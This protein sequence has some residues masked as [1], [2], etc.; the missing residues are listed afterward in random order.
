MP[1]KTNKLLLL[2]V[3]II[4]L[5]MVIL[6][7]AAPY[8]RGTAYPKYSTY[9][10][11]PIGSKLFFN[12]L[13]SMPNL[14]VE[15]IL[16]PLFSA[17]FAPQTTIINCGVP[18]ADFQSYLPEEEIINDDDSIPIVSNGFAKFAKDGAIV[19]I[20]L[21]TAK[22]FLDL[23][24]GNS[25]KDDR[26]FNKKSPDSFLIDDNGEQIFAEL[27][28]NTDSSLPAHLAWN[29]EF[30]L[31]GKI[32]KEKWQVIYRFK[33]KPVVLERKYGKGSIVVVCAS[34]NISNQAL[35]LSRQP[36]FLAWLI[37]DAK[38]IFFNETQLGVG[39]KPGVSA[40]VIHYRL[41]GFFFAILALMLLFV[42]KSS[43]PLVPYY[44]I[45]EMKSRTKHG[46]D[47]HAGLHNLLKK[48]IT[49]WD[50]LQKG[51]ALWEQQ[52]ARK[53]PILKKQIKKV[54]ELIENNNKI[55][56]KHRDI[57]NIY[58]HIV[59]ILTERK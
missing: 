51:H 38:E 58:N 42:W 14:K 12:S 20:M 57:K 32:V 33:N 34:Y 8:L 49:Q 21:S 26:D 2:F 44:S 28:E 31:R 7:V 37:G 15:R 43:N 41:Q 46:K 50:I 1:K 18:S 25:T 35:L 55:P 24:L 36:S 22:N 52:A 39:E 47:S 56:Q 48:S 19:G 17:K 27:A 11:D 3:G 23:L 5:S 30:F 6:L 54:N 29:D 45:Q 10:A 13:K 53:N 16:K 4:L 59:T 9:R 40:L